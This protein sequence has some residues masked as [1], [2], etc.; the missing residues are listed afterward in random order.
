MAVLLQGTKNGLCRGHHTHILNFSRKRMGL[1][2]R[3]TTTARRSTFASVEDIMMCVCLGIGYPDQ[4]PFWM[5]C[6]WVTLLLL[7]LILITVDVGSD[8][9]GI[10]AVSTLLLLSFFT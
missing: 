2:K 6:W 1:P 10:V 3:N 7:L 4:L 9:G 8:V 5:I